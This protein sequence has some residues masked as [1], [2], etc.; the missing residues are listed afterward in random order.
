MKGGELMK[1]QWMTPKIEELDVNKT[2]W[3]SGFGKICTWTP[4]TGLV[5]RD[6]GGGSGGDEGN[7]GFES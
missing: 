3:G 2:M 5:C 6:I 4:R 7:E 1:K